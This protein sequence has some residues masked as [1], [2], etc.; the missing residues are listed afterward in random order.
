M[1]R[2]VVWLFYRTSDIP[3]D[4]R[5]DATGA[6]KLFKIVIL[7][8]LSHTTVWLM[9]PQTPNASGGFD[10]GSFKWASLPDMAADLYR[11]LWFWCH[12][13]SEYFMRGESLECSRFRGE[14]HGDDNA[15]FVYEH[16]MN[17][18]QMTHQC[19]CC[20]KTFREFPSNHTPRMVTVDILA[21]TQKDDNILFIISVH[22]SLPL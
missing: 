3:A 2:V 20:Y 16:Q 15:V 10:P 5:Q 14:W 8:P 7:V 11:V 12:G 4:N 19:K 1:D 9:Q 22:Y 13:L 18:T 17:Y 6:D 21:S